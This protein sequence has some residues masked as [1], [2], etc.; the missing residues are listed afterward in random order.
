MEANSELPEGILVKLQN[1]DASLGNIEDLLKPFLKIP[2]NDIVEKVNDP[3]QNARLSLMVSYAV[4]SLFWA[5]LVTQGVNA[6]N[7][8]I[9]NELKRIKDNMGKVKLAEER[10]KM[11]RVDTHAAKR[12]IR[13][14]L[15]QPPTAA[16]SAA[17]A[18][19]SS[20][21]ATP[22]V[23][24]S[25][26]QGEEEEVRTKKKK[27][28]RKRENGNKNE[29]ENK[30][31]NEDENEEEENSEKKKKKKKKKKVKQD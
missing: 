26:Q 30:N 17:P 5:Y 31:E 29:D 4:N 18:E 23:D 20:S 13:N 27:K 1:F 24:N 19:G 14:A 16:A 7:H 15:W 22:D 9:R 12:F 6:K 28:K 3:L 8:P 2:I 21:P 25:Q 10:K 11:A